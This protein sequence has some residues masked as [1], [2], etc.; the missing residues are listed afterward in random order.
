MLVPQAW[1][2]Y[3]VRT[4]KIPNCGGVVGTYTADRKTLRTAVLELI[5]YLKYNSLMSNDYTYR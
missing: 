4:I 2:K 5:L 3:L 1:Y